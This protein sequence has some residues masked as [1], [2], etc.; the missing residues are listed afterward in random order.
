MRATS[1]HIGLNFYDHNNY[2]QASDLNSS[3]RDAAE[4]YRLARKWGYTLLDGSSLPTW[5]SRVPPNV[6]LDSAATSEAVRN[7]IAEV[8]AGLRQRGDVFFLTFSGHGA[9]IPDRDGDEDDHRDEA[10]CL[11]DHLL[12]DDTIKCMLSKFAAGVRIYIVSD[13]CHSQSDVLAED[14]VLDNLDKVVRSAVLRSDVDV[15]TSTSFRMSAPNELTVETKQVITLSAGAVPSDPPVAKSASGRRLLHGEDKA[16]TKGE[17][18]SIWTR[19]KE[20]YLAE[21]AA[22]CSSSAQIDAFVV[23]FA[24]CGDRENTPDGPAPST[25]SFYT[26]AFLEII[27]PGFTGNA[28]ELT[29]EIKRVKTVPLNADFSLSGAETRQR[30]SSLRERAALHSVASPAKVRFRRDTFN[31]LRSR[32]HAVLREGKSTSGYPSA[33]GHRSRR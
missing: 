13:C 32:A 14:I 21:P 1:L 25:N 20:R 19:N 15:K 31:R 30:L 12:I 22:T 33:D 26:Q 6:L 2:P 9:R 8:S 17:A 5:T 11:Y 24:A 4:M 16:I 27:D 23:S 18:R 10:I 3:M 28:D 29:K 7:K